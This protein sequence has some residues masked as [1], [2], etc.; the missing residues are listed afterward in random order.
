MAVFPTNLRMRKLTDVG[1]FN[2]SKRGN[3]TDGNI[4]IDVIFVDGK[5]FQ[6]KARCFKVIICI[7][8]RTNLNGI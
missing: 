7:F 5:I 6:M 3:T 4:D 1:K 2:V 8:M